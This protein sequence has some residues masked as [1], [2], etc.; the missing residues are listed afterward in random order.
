M[1]FMF[2]I[3]VSFLI[4]TK[5][6]NGLLSGKYSP[7]LSADE[8]DIDKLGMVVLIP[9]HIYFIFSFPKTN[10]FFPHNTGF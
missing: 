8:E 2:N 6:A 7:L 9:T 1:T 10:S 3:H 5:L 4:R